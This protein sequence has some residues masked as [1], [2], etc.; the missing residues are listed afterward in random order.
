MQNKINLPFEIMNKILKM[1]PI[2]P[3]VKI[4]EREF[5]NYEDYIDGD[6]NILFYEYITKLKYLYEV[7]DIKKVK[8]NR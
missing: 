5:Y 4:I 8:N 7:F 6:Y 3:I 1:R 2:H